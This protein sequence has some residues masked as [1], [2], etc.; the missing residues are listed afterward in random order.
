MSAKVFVRK[1]GRRRRVEVPT[2]EPLGIFNPA[3][4]SPRKGSESASSCSREAA[5]R[6][7]K[8][9]TRLRPSPVT[10]AGQADRG[11][12]SRLSQP[13]DEGQN[14][15][16]CRAMEHRMSRVHTIRVSGG[17][18]WAGGLEDSSSCVR[19]MYAMLVG[20]ADMPKIRVLQRDEA[21]SL[22]MSLR[23]DEGNTFMKVRGS[24]PS[25]T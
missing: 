17:H 12:H 22:H 8:C 14:P 18:G 4:L 23:V 6:Q 10:K 5:P 20:G 7:A 9:S 24:L 19:R 2:T 3:E 11:Q 13:V 16:R 25:T 1:F 15:G 21:L